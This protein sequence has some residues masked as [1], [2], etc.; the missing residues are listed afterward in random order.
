M[1]R[2]PSASP[3]PYV[4]L[5]ASL[6]VMN[7]DEVLVSKVYV[8]LQKFSAHVE[9]ATQLEIP[10]AGLL[11]NAKCQA[12]DPERVLNVSQCANNEKNAQI[13]R[14]AV[15]DHK[16]ILCRCAAEGVRSECM[17]Q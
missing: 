1:P 4:M 9:P 10:A 14:A 6:L 13:R 3:D 7:E 15:H 5:N 11:A 16:E 2:V 17:A 8:C 12:R